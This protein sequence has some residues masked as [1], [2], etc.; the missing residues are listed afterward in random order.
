[1]A[2][3]NYANEMRKTLEAQTQLAPQLF[4]SQQ[5]FAPLYNS[6]NLQNLNDFL[7]GTPEQSY[8]Q[9]AWQ[10][11]IYGDEDGA[12][13]GKI[14]YNG[15]KFGGY[16]DGQWKGG[17]DPYNF[18]GGEDSNFL[19]DLNSDMSKPPSLQL[20]NILDGSSALFGDDDKKT[21]KKGRYIPYG[22]GVRPAQRGFLDLYSN[23][24]MPVVDETTARS[25]SYQRE[26]DVADV[27]KLSPAMREALR[28]ANPEAAA[29]LDE[30]D[31][32][33]MGDLEL[34]ASLN[35]SETRN[36]Q[37][38]LRAGQSARGM[39]VGPLDNFQ[40]ALTSLDYGRGLQDSRRGF[41]RQTVDDL[42]SFYTNPF[43]TILA[44]GN[45][46]AA[47]GLG[48]ANQSLMNSAVSNLFNPESSYAGDVYG[49]NFNYSA[50]KHINSENNQNALIAA[51][52]SSVGGMAGGA[53][54]MI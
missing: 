50:A 42:S 39:G 49:S 18:S 40:E 3:R 17:N 25:A 12:Q 7:L 32:Q 27:Q 29:L 30:L 14:V 46:N 13:G 35:P 48:Q 23:E 2:Y 21:L 37:Q 6:L 45:N 5:Q 19:A 4:Q 24:I 1:M 54:G 43:E 52:I 20:M 16:H 41:A 36:I 44:R 38:A 51:G 15:N 9:W 8:Q 31:R 53:M 34:G 47:L 26:H 10:K 28:K 22:T 33:A 11:P